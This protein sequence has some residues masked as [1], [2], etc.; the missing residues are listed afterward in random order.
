MQQFN[1]Y[2]TLNV[3][4]PKNFNMYVVIDTLTS[5]I[6][7]PNINCIPLPIQS[8]FFFPNLNRFHEGVLEILCS[9][10]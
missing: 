8:E 6:W 9:Q 7:H 1:N 4:V 10:E 5:H 2:S 3:D